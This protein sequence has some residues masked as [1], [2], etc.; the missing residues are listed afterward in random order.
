MPRNGFRDLHTLG[1][2]LMK[3]GVDYDLKSANDF[4]MVLD[5]L[6]SNP[7]VFLVLKNGEIVLLSNVL[8]PS[9]ITVTGLCVSFEDVLYG[10][11]NMLV[12]I[13]PDFSLLNDKVQEDDKSYVETLEILVLET[14]A[15]I[16]S[17]RNQVIFL[18]KV[19]GDYKESLFLEKG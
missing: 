17:L 15:T 7:Y 8:S 1:S 10:D 9:V 14:E 2:F 12:P 4:F 6:Q 5:T 11:D 16:L 19:L 13:P 18:E 3:F